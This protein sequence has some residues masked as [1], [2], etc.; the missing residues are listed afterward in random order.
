VDFLQATLRGINLNQ[1]ALYRVNF[2]DVSL[3]GI[4]NLDRSRSIGPSTI[5]TSTLERTAVELANATARVEAVA[6]FLNQAGQSNRDRTICR[7][8]SSRPAI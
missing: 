7:S 1:A 8:I 5:D 4:T 2:A 3:A 6:T